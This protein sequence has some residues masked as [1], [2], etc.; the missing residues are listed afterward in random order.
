MNIMRTRIQ[1]CFA[2]ILFV[3]SCSEDNIIPKK[4]DIHNVDIGIYHLLQSSIDTIPYLGKKSIVF[5]DSNSN[6]IVFEIIEK[7]I[8]QNKGEYFYSD[9][10]KYHFS[11]QTKL[12]TIRNDSLKIE[13]I[14]SLES[15][16]YFI[17]PKKE[18]VADIINITLMDPG[19]EYTY[20]EVFYHVTNNR[21]WPSSWQYQAIKEKKILNRI[22][23]DVLHNEFQ[24]PLSFVYFNYKYGII[25]F[26]DLSGKLWIFDKLI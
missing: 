3:F 24:D 25:S 15:L 23:Q 13:F 17:E 1:F 21:T 22:F 6:S 20:R 5:V 2:I 4:D 18:Y 16:P 8:T 19:I 12:F 10:I 7:P 14:F 9:S 11:F 26:T